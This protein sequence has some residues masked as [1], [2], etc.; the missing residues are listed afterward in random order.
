M[1]CRGFG[2]VSWHVTIN[3]D[4]WG[5]LS[6]DPSPCNSWRTYIPTQ[7]WAYLFIV[8]PQFWFKIYWRF[9]FLIKTARTWLLLE[10]YFL[11]KLGRG[12]HFSERTELTLGHSFRV[13]MQSFLFLFKNVKL[14]R[15]SL[16]RIFTIEKYKSNWG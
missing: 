11:A 12:I 2:L 9:I 5:W 13:L 15:Y 7:F 8:R 4:F 14:K 3:C 16:I 6:V 10:K 1:V